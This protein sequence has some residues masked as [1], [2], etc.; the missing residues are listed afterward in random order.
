MAADG[1]VQQVN[2]K[3][4]LRF[5]RLIDK[6]LERVWAAIATPD[7]I[8]GWLGDAHLELKQDAPIRLRFDKTMG[9]VVEGQ[10]TAVDPP[11]LLEYTFGQ[12]DSVL[13]WE[14][15][16]APGGQ[17]SLVISHTLPSPDQA[18]SAL[19]GW[20]TLLDM[21]PAAIDGDDP[22]WSR[23]RWDEVHAEYESVMG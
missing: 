21:I 15:S 18:S 20:H 16:E 22:Q 2:G 3:H 14:L 10:I 1:T 9:N 4:V 11:T 8:A 6:P 19:A 5:E 12:P 7:G 13:R 23:A 17:T